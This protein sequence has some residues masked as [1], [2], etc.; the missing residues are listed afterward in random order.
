MESLIGT[1]SSVDIKIFED[2]NAWKPNDKNA[3]RKTIAMFD[4]QVRWSKKRVVS[5]AKIGSH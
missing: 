3:A 1:L 4:E 5:L 2:R